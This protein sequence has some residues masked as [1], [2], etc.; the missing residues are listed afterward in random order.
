[1][2]QNVKQAQADISQRP[3]DF[4]YPEGYR[5]MLNEVF[6]DLP[7]EERAAAFN[8]FIRGLLLY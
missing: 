5:E 1:M 3:V 7:E 4:T 8:N 2:E 6:D